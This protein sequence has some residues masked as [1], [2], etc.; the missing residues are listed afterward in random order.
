MKSSIPAELWLDDWVALP[1][2]ARK[3]MLGRCSTCRRNL[4]S[5]PKSHLNNKRKAIPQETLP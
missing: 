1:F 3:G 5:W 2:V 4:G